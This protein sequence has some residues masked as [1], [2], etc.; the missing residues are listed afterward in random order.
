MTGLM[1]GRRTLLAGC[2]ALAGLGWTGLF[3]G[4]L[5]WPDPDFGTVDPGAA[6]FDVAALTAVV[7]D[8]MAGNSQAV[9]VLRGGRIAAER[10]VEG[11]DRHTARPLAS[12][13]KSMVAMLT[14]MAIDDGFIESV[15]QSVS[16]F[17]PQWR[18]TPKEAISVRHLLTM[19]SGLSSRGLKAR[20]EERDQFAVNAAA[21]LDHP[22]GTAWEYNTPI[23]H[24]LFHLVERAAGEPF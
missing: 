4:D 17:F 19:T 9:M 16:A 8:L 13:T 23:Y 18:G 6:G 21:E 14:G 1:I 22:P 15:E 10:Y 24:L 3:A 7:D 12:A 20:G 11:W 5:A 2:G